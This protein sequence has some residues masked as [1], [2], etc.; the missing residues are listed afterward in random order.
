MGDL[1]RNDMEKQIRQTPKRLV[2]IRCPA[3]VLAA[4]ILAGL[5]PSPV[6]A[7]E[8]A[9][10]RGTLEGAGE[11][12][13]ELEKIPP[14]EGRTLYSGRYFHPRHGVDIPLRGTP[15]K[16]HESAPRRESAA[17]DDLPAG[18]GEG[19]PDALWQGRVQDAVFQGVRE[20]A[21]TGVKRVFRL[22][23]VAAYD[24]RNKYPRWIDMRR[25]PYEYLKLK[26]HAVPEGEAIGGEAVAYRMWRDPRSK[27]RYPRLA[28]HPDP[29]VFRKVNALLEQ[30]HWESTLLALECQAA[31]YDSSPAARPG[32]PDH[33]GDEVSVTY[34]TVTLMSVIKDGRYHCGGT[35]PSDYFSPSTFDLIR[36]ETLDWNRLFRAF[37]KDEYGY[38]EA[39]PETLKFIAHLDQDGRYHA[40]AGMAENKEAPGFGGNSAARGKN[41]RA[42][43]FIRNHLTLYF[44]EPGKLNLVISGGNRCC[45][46]PNGP[47]YSVPFAELKKPF[48]KPGAAKYL[49]PERE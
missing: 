49:F 7:G 41:R 46:F 8:R 30:R 9:V 11:I 12:V 6:L 37:K 20:D 13:M 24:H 1:A 5:P 26:D 15:D 31:M 22:E 3:L 42:A 28:R 16:L 10:Y 32:S 29:E 47:Y 43:S 40:A 21:R 38:K 25:T 19:V 39:S 44:S 27:L 18:A 23:R 33:G 36:G 45:A 35:G 17:A 14:E 34:L 2:N 48:L 4:A